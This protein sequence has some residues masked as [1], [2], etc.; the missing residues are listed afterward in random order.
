MLWDGDVAR[1]RLDEEKYWMFVVVDYFVCFGVVD[2]V[3]EF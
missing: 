3:F 1:R 2:D